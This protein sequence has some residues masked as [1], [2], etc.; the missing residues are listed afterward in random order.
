MTTA[1]DTLSFI[2]VGCCACVVF[3]VVLWLGYTL[4]SEDCANVL[5]RLERAELSGVLR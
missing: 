2:F 3:L 1:R 4:G 5:E